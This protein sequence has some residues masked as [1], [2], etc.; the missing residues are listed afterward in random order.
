MDNYNEMIHSDNNGVEH[1]EGIRK[2]EKVVLRHFMQMLFNYSFPNKLL[3][4]SK[5][6]H[7][8]TNR[9]DF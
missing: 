4:I 3:V 1:I 9:K 6:N 7:R 8:K 2:W 5:I